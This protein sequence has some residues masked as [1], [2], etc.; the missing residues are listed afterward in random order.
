METS[1]NR[2]KFIQLAGACGLGVVSASSLF[3]CAAQSPGH[4]SPKDQ[5]DAV[6]ADFV[7]VGAGAGGLKAALA[8]AE[9]NKTAVLLEKEA[10]VGG[11]TALSAGTIHAPGTSLQDEQGYEGDTVEAYIEYMTDPDSPYATTEHPLCEALYKGAVAMVEELAADGVP[12][13]PIEDWDIRAHNVEGGGGMLVKYLEQKVA[14]TN[15]EVRKSTAAKSLIVE[16]GTVVGVQDDQGTAYLAPAVILATGGF[17]NNPELVAKYVPEFSDIRVLGAAGTEGDGLIMAQEVGA[18]PWHLEEGEH[19]YFV[20]TEGTTDMSVP[21]ASAPGIIVNINGDRFH[22]EEAHYDVAG[23]EGMKQPEHRAFYIFDETIRQDYPIFEDY[24]KEGIVISADSL[25]ALVAE[26]GTENL[27]QTLEHY[28]EMMSRGVDE[29]FGREGLLAPING[30]QFYAMGIEPVIYYSY[31]GLAIDPDAHVL[32]ATGSP[33]KGLF[34]CGE[35]CASSE[36]KEG[37]SYTSGIS[38]GYVFGANAVRAAVAEG[39]V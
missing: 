28:N 6:L 1:I 21:P 17:S 37:L 14:S 30:P 18:D 23:K 20:S 7:I 5:S 35:V 4:V 31:G 29:D 11:D 16:D 25:D 15:T 34:A 38:Q 3:G 26:I 12:F 13:L 10:V 2:R 36:I 39:L 27:P 33:I 19:T 24:F 22:N 9:A 32:D 8:A